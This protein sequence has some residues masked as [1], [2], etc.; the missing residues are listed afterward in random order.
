[1][2]KAIIFD[3]DGTLAPLNLDFSHLRREVLKIAYQYLPPEA[4]NSFNDMPVLEMI[5]ELEGV[6]EE[7][8]QEFKDQAFLKLNELEI[9]AAKKKALFPYTRRVL[10]YLNGKSIRIGIITRTCMGAV[11]QVFPDFED[12]VSAVITR[13]HVRRVKPHPE[14]ILK[15]L[16]ILCVHA[17]DAMVVGDHVTDIIGGKLAGTKTA[18]VLTGRTERDEFLKLEPTYILNDISEILEIV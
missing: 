15:I 6:L 9:E 5:Y 14:H 10:N 8:G 13:E 1:M 11:T 3:F 17:Y 16:Q 7:R 18:A 4:L 12:Y 2:V